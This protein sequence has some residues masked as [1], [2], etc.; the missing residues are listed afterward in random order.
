MGPV[1]GD[2]KVD[3]FYQQLQEIINQTPNTHILVVGGDRILNWKRCT[4]KLGDR[5]R[6]Y[7]Y[8]ASNESGLGL[9]E[10]AICNNLVLTNNQGQIRKV[11]IARARH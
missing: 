9:M 7:C 8:A 11:D 3:N 10:L 4:G 6:P 1:H 2:D 5:R